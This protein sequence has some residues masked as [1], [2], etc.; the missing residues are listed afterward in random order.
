MQGYLYKYHCR[1]CSVNQATRK[2]IVIKTQI[3]TPPKSRD[4]G[5]NASQTLTPLRFECHKPAVTL[6]DTRDNSPSLS[7]IGYPAN[8]TR[9]ALLNP[10]VSGTSPRVV[11][12]VGVGAAI[13]GTFPL[14]PVAGQ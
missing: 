2:P 5:D 14:L 7:A 9:C 13:S 3:R 1:H 4:I 11:D 10:K 8:K 12:A 6:N